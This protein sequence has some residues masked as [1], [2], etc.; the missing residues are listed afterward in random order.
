M[1]SRPLARS[2]GILAAACVVATTATAQEQPEP[3][4]PAPDEQT[5][6]GPLGLT[7]KDPILTQT[8]NAT[9]IEYDFEEI[10]EDK[11]PTLELDSVDGLLDRVVEATRS[12]Q[13]KT[14]L[15][16]GFAYTMLFQQASAGPGDRTGTSGDIDLFGDWT[17]IGR[18]TPNTGRL[19]FSGEYRFKVGDQ[20]ASD[21]RGQIGSLQGTTGGFNDRG[22]AV[23]DI[24]WAQR[25]FDGKLRFL[26]GRADISD[27]F[28]GHWLQGINHFFSNRNFSANS[29][30]AFPA[31]HVTAG[32]LSIVPVDWFYFSAGMANGYGR[33]TINDMKYLDEADFFY[34]A[35]AGFTPTIEGVGHGRYRVFFWHMD[36]RDLLSLPDDWGFSVIAEQRIGEEFQVF[37]RYG[38]A[39]DGSLT[40]IK[41]AAEIGGAVWGLLGS[42]DNITG[43][44][45]GVSEPANDDLRDEY[46]VEGFHRFQL[47]R[48][49]Q[50]SVGMQGIFDPSNA[51][52]DDAIAVL[53]LRFRIAF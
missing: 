11:E 7:L 48:H 39:E 13:D 19:F 34:S 53:S 10:L 3:R 38:W 47:T 21:L 31:G 25:L 45:F 50:F 37:A 44:A 8:D 33:S 30:T 4:A 52:D 27:Y 29:T 35:E 32:G 23:R 18:G 2:L 9:T 20:P 46:V 26:I 1:K 51:P 17:L 15:L 16:L 28:G 5:E 41:S 49:T 36:E 24:F 42:R 43:I 22:W 14:G 40:G 6:I 12:L